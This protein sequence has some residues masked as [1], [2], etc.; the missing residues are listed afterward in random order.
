[1]KPGEFIEISALIETQDNSEPQLTIDY[2]DIINCRLE[3]SIVEENQSKAPKLIIDYFPSW[4]KKSIKWII[5][6]TI[7][8]L[9]ISMIIMMIFKI[10]KPAEGEDKMYIKIVTILTVLIMCI[11]ISSPIFWFFKI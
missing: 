5:V 7:A 4:L 10:V 8:L 9:I 1:L 11:I 3:N 6:I 2:Q